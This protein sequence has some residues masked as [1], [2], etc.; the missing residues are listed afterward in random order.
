MAIWDI[1]RKKQVQETKKIK[2]DNLDEE[3][4]KEKKN[5][6]EQS[7]N[8]NKEIETLV[9]DFSSKIQDI[10]PSIKKLNIDKRKENEKLKEFVVDNLSNYV[11]HL[12]KLIEDFSVLE[13]NKGEDYAEQVQKTFNRFSK[14]SIANFERATILIGKEMGSA[15]EIVNWKI[16]RWGLTLKLG[17]FSL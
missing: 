9:K 11:A 14:N 5:L 6:E 16:W 2:L 17:L 1:F 4:K 13:K 15:K 8:F 10:L 12:E 7:G 3:I